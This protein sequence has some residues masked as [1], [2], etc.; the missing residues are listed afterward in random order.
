MIKPVVILHL[1]FAVSSAFNSEQFL[2]KNCAETDKSLHCSKF[3]W[4][5]Q[6][7]NEVQNKNFIISKASRIE[8]ESV[9]IG[10][11]NE[12]FINK[13]PNAVEVVLND[14][15]V[16]LNSSRTSISQENTNLENLEIHHSVIYESKDSISFNLLRELKTFELAFPTFKDSAEID[17][18][19]L[20][21]NVN[22]NSVILTGPNIKSISAGAFENLRRLQELTIRGTLLSS[23]PQTLLKNNHNLVTLNLGYNRIN[24]IP[25][26]YFF[27]KNLEGLSLSNNQIRFVNNMRFNG[28]SKLRELNLGSNGISVLSSVALKNLKSLQVLGLDNNELQSLTRQHLENNVYLKE[29]YISQNRFVELPNDLFDGLNNL[30]YVRSDL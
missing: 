9:D 5:I 22:L 1:L 11:L 28:L 15:V 24:S 27:P 18:A 30:E 21:K 19:L 10:I 13:F 4:T 29:I 8:L 7:Q 17:D 14:C 25:T 23:L 12:N 3:K 16:Y 2:S 6:E 26:D 20:S